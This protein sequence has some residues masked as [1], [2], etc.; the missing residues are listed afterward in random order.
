MT[1]RV[2]VVLVAEGLSV[3]WKKEVRKQLYRGL[4]SVVLE[5]DCSQKESQKKSGERGKVLMNSELPAEMA[6]GSG[7]T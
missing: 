1:S 2:F 7:L 4:K 3:E 6:S 5:L